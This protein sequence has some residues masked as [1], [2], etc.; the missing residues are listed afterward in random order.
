FIDMRKTQAILVALQY[1]ILAQNSQQFSHGIEDAIIAIN[2]DLNVIHETVFTDDDIVLFGDD[3]S[4][5]QIDTKGPEIFVP[6][7]SLNPL[8]QARDFIKNQSNKDCVMMLSTISDNATQYHQSHTQFVLE[9][10]LMVNFIAKQVVDPVSIYR[11]IC[12]HDIALATHPELLNKKTKLSA[13]EINELKQHPLHGSKI[14]QELS[15]SDETELLVLHHHEH[16]DGSGY[17]FGLQKDNISEQGKL[18]AIVDSFHEAMEKN[19]HLSLKKQILRGLYDIHQ[20]AGRFYDPTWAKLFSDAL[21]EY[22]VPDLA[23]RFRQ[24]S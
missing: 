11:G 12:L 16:L 21:R 19:A 7:V 3:E 15:Y 20:H 18:A 9:L 1:I 24:A 17:P 14:V 6:N 2:Q 23:N 4:A 10:A 22:W 5:S 8:E 13:S